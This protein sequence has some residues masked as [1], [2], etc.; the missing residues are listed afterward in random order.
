MPC[1]CPARVLAR[2]G[3][4]I[5]GLRFSVLGL[6]SYEGEL[7]VVRKMLAFARGIRMRPA[8]C[9]RSASAQAR[10]MAQAAVS[11]HAL[12]SGVRRYSSCCHSCVVSAS[13]DARTASSVLAGA[14]L[15]QHHI[16]RGG[17][18]RRAA[19]LGAD[20]IRSIARVLSCAGAIC[21]SY[22]S[23]SCLHCNPLHPHP[24]S[25]TDCVHG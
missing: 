12:L 7:S 4:G 2:V 9:V 13:S 24:P 16:A 15:Y 18:D 6:S 11:Q 14:T 8:I 1:L 21:E 23:R 3:F 22:G 5:H 19:H 10:S 17:L 20:L 25:L